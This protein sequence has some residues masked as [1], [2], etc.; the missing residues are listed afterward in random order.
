MAPQLSRGQE[1]ARALR[2]GKGTNYSCV[3]L[4]GGLG[5]HTRP[6][7]IL[8]SKEKGEGRGGAPPPPRLPPGILQPFLGLSPGDRDSGLLARA[9]GDPTLQV[10]KLAEVLAEDTTALKVSWDTDSIL[11]GQDG[12]SRP[13]VIWGSG[14]A[15][16][17]T[18]KCQENASE[19]A[20]CTCQGIP[21]SPWLHL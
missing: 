18:H 17:L 13:V 9:H 8:C 12:R 1:L 2:L 15:G 14:Q 19:L 5:D 7:P 4:W 10:M 16:Q 21:K 3:G 11:G 20:D 6:F